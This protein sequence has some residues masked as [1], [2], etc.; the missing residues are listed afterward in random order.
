M[1]GLLGGKKIIIPRNMA[2]EGTPLKTFLGVD[3]RKEQILGRVASAV[4][5][6]ICFK[7]QLKLHKRLLFEFF[8]YNERRE[9]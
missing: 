5:P 3:S 9:W 8:P 4:A 2:G 6:S 1:L 7:E